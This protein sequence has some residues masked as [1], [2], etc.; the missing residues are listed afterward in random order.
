MEENKKE[1]IAVG[2]DTQEKDS[3]LSEAVV[4]EIIHAFKDIIIEWINKHYQ[5]IGTSK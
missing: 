4:I 2:R 5:S 3:I 1:I